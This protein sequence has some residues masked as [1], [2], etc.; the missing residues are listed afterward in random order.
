[1]H[2]GMNV[3]AAIKALVCHFCAALCHAQEG[4]AEQSGVVSAPPSCELWL[5]FLLRCA[6]SWRFGGRRPLAWARSSWL[7][8]CKAF[9]ADAL[10]LHTCCGHLQNQPRKN[11]VARQT[12][13][14]ADAWNPR[15][16]AAALGHRKEDQVEQSSF[17][18]S[19]V[20]KKQFLSGR[21]RWS[22]CFNE[23]WLEFSRDAFYRSYLQDP[24]VQFLLHR[25]AD[26]AKQGCVEWGNQ[27]SDQGWCCQNWWRCLVAGMRQAMCQ[28]EAI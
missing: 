7:H 12:P 13:R 22:A 24:T 27:G 17:C 9:C 5:G 1:M 8:M 4:Q 21:W 10:S 16:R 11:A 26:L 25:W 6:F 20:L 2:Q 3:A 15:L 28:Q 14:Q 23:P 18:A 19:F